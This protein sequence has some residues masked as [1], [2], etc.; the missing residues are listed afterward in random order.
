[1]R[2]APP[3]IILPEQMLGAY[4]GWSVAMPRLGKA[5]KTRRRVPS[6]ERSRAT[7]EA[8]LEGTART[9]VKRGYAGTTT[10][11]IAQEAGVGIGSF[12]EYFEDKDAAVSAVVNRF[13]ER[14]FAHAVEAARTALHKPRPEAVRLFI[15]DMVEFVADNAPLVRTLHQQVPF[16]WGLP[17]V[18]GLVG[19]LERFGLE[20]A[21]P[22]GAH[23]APGSQDRFYVV[24]VA[25][26]SC[27]LQIATD[28]AA[29][30]RR[31]QLT[32][33]LALLIA[34]YLRLESP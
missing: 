34:L 30:A 5:M 25:V 24:G 31:R 12:Y 16:V 4:S 7:V 20:L 33:E 8:L 2:R 6:S 23:A 19:Q 28:P 22:A 15:G 32:D 21:H 3:S 27:V 14:A 11:H 26:G 1:L 17:R 29:V 9:L 18:Q 13:T 10:N